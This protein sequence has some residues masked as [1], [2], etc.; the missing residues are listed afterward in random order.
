MIF[1]PQDARG[2]PFKYGICA[3]VLVGSA[4]VMARFAARIEFTVKN[5]RSEP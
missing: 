2:L 3:L 4:G 5:V 1:A